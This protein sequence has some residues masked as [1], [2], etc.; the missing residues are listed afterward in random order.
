M[1]QSNGFKVIGTRPVRHDGVDKVTGRALYGADVRLNGQLYGAMLRSP[2]AHA[3]IVAIDTSEAAAVP[4]VKAI[5][6]GADLPHVG[7]QIADIGEGA[8]NLRH[9]SANILA[10]RKALYFGHAIAAVAATSLTAAQQAVNKIK[11]T[12]EELPP[13]LNLRDAMAAGAAPL[14]PDVFTDELGEKS[15]TPSNIAEHLRHEKG[16]I[17]AGFAEAEVVVE[18]EFVTGT[19]HQGYIEPHSATVQWNADGQLTVYCSTQGAFGVRREMSEILGVPISHVK[20]VPTEIGGGFGGKLNVYLEPVCALLSRKAGGRP[21]KMTMSRADVLAATGPTSASIVR[22][23]L[24][25]RR[26]GTLTA[27]QAWMA[28]EAGAFPGSPVGSAA[29]VIL[30]PYDIPNVVIDGFDVLCNKPKAN[31]YRAPGGTNAAYAAESMIDELARALKMGPIEIRLKNAAREGTRR[32]DGPVFPRIGFVET[33]EALLHHPHFQSRLERATGS[34]RRG[35]GIAAGFWFNWGGTSSASAQVNPDGTVA[36]SEGSTD[37][38]GT[39]TSIAM[40]LAESIGIPVNLVKP[41]VVDTDSVGYNDATGGS[42]TTFATGMVAYELGQKLREELIAH[43]ARQFEVEAAA[44]RFE[45]GAFRTDGKPPLSYFDVCGALR[46]TGGEIVAS[47]SM[48]TKGEGPAFGAH[49][50]DVEVDIETGKVKILR[51]TAAQDVGRAIYP[52][53][54]EGQI[55]GGVAQGVGWALNEEYLYDKAGHMLNAGF[56]DYRMPTALDLPMIEALI[57][58]VPNPRHPYGVRGV[59][60]V[61]IVPPA[62]AVA[63]AIFDALGVRMTELPMSP[64]RNIAALAAAGVAA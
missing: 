44:V 23:K 6:T 46:D 60:E 37:I 11:V 5:V 38:G 39:R 14:H 36:L 1:T 2:H 21:V 3:R 9:L 24:G 26:D 13:V 34:R 25:A 8:V 17:A 45:D 19:V 53:F 54:V 22:V 52:P 7:D 29:G 12:W 47:V 55:Q 43:A 15:T 49:L 41:Q 61:P 18:R 48:R 4:G 62:G 63:N 35:R 30:A 10:G 42:R 33:L 64:A 20:V 16:D 57:V 28:F 50:V 40:Q 51:Y 56:L 27:A 58:E 59:G 32:A 31:A